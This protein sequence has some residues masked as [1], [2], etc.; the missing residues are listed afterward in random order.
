VFIHFYENSI[1]SSTL[2]KKIFAGII[3]IRLNLLTMRILLFFFMFAGMQAFG[4]N[5]GKNI[6]KISPFRFMLSFRAAYERMLNDK[7]AIELTGTSYYSY[8]LFPGYRVDL[9]GKYYCAADDKIIPFLRIKV[10]GGDLYPYTYDDMYQDVSYPTFTSGHKDH[11]A[12]KGFGAGLGFKQ[13]INEK[14]ALVLEFIAGANFCFYK[15]R[16]QRN[17]YMDGT[18]IDFDTSRRGSYS[19]IGYFKGTGPGSVLDIG[20]NFGIQF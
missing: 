7:F 13:F 12:M 1:R 10:I 9:S 2:E 6:I 17:T 16:H 4:Q 19:S 8:N 11:F 5:P 3:T 15:S 18:L 14:E 20:V